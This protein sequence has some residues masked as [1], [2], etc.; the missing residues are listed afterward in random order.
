MPQATAEAVARQVGALSPAAALAPTSSLTGV[1]FDGLGGL[2]QAQAA[3][4]LAVLSRV[5]PLHKLKLVELLQAQVRGGKAAREV[6]GLGG[7]DRDRLRQRCWGVAVPDCVEPPHC[8]TMRGLQPC[9]H[10]AGLTTVCFEAAALSIELL[11]RDMPC[12]GPPQGHVVA[13][14]GDGVNDAPA[15]MRSDI[16]VAM[17]SG[18]AVAKSAADMVLADDNFATIVFAGEVGRG[19]GDACLGVERRAGDR[20]ARGAVRI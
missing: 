15:L 5:E 18:T 16:G 13:M 17:G 10:A 20:V 8:V 14:T 7:G 9:P 19:G 11:W 1:E 2:G 12:A 3:G 4:G 6:V